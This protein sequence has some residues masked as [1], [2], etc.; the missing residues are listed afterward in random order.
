MRGWNVMWE[1]CLYYPD[2]QF[3]KYQKVIN[4]RHFKL[5]AMKV[6]HKILDDIILNGLGFDDSTPGPLIVVKQGD[7]VFITVE[8]HFDEPTSLHVHG[9]S[10]PNSQDGIPEIEPTP[11]IQPGESYT[12]RFIAWQSGTFFYHSGNPLHIS[13]GMIGGFIVL[14][15]TTYEMPDRD[16]TLILQQWE[17][18]QPKKGK[19]E[20]GTFKPEKFD[21]SP[22]FFTING[23]AFPSTSPL[24]TMYGE[25][26]RIRFINKSNAAHSMH[27]HGHDFR[28]AEVDGFSRNEYQDTLNVP[29]GQ[30]CS[31]EFTANNPGVWPI[32]GTKTFHQTNN[33]VAPGGMIT[34]LIYN[35]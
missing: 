31:I 29:S 20:P 2:G 5:K 24:R 3:A 25:K 16:C 34:K 12:Y 17:L 7:W 19:V 6:K 18:P 32:N 14:P 35:N 21:V 30:R 1:D 27:V 28:L 8:N 23:K 4:G 9:L 33:G 26:L 11:L 10:K 15:Q 22:N 13:L